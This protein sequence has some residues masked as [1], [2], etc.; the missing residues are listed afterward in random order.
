[1]TRETGTQHDMLNQQPNHDRRMRIIDRLDEI[2]VQGAKNLAI[3]NGGAVIAMLA[4]V[5]ALINKPEYLC[6]CFKT[7]ALRAL[8]CFLLGA[9]LAAIT[10]FFHHGYVYRTYQ[11]TNTQMKWKKIVWGILITSATFAL[12]GGSFVT[13]GIWKAI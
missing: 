7:Y 8:I 5:Q 4:S 6:L 13:Y 11:D 2:I 10:F 1:M 12:G 9:F 3:L